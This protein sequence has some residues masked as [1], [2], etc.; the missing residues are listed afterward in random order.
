[1]S[2]AGQPPRPL[3]D[4]LLEAL[5]VLVLLGLLVAA[6]RVF[7]ILGAGA[8]TIASVGI[9]LLG[10]TVLANLLE[11]VGLPHLTGY[12]LAG[13]AAGP[14]ALNLVDHRA[15]EELTPV[16]GLALS[17]I[18]LAGG[19]ELRLASLRNGLRSLAWATLWQNLL[20]MA[21]LAAVFLAARPLLPFLKD[22]P[23]AGVIGVGLVWG[24]MAVTR[25]P[26]ATL[27]ILSQ[28]RAKGPLA[29]FTLNFVMTSDV[30]VV[31]LLAVVMTIARPLILPGSDL[32]LSAVRELGVEV[33]GSI[34]VGTTIGLFL[35]AYLRLVGGGLV[36]M[37][38]ALGVVF[39]EVF[40]YL[41]FDWL[42]I[43]MTA[44]FVVQNLSRQGERFVTA[45][46]STGEIVY[47]IFFGVAGAHLDLPVLR[48]L[49][50]V[51]LLFA[52]A[53]GIT[54]W[55]AGR[56]AS[57]YAADP[58]AIRSWGWSG[59]VSQA[60]LALGIAASIQAEFPA[61][62]AG[63]GAL[64]VAT[65]AMNEMVGPVLFKLALDRCGETQGEAEEAEGA[66]AAEAAFEP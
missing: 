12:L 30:V 42:L 16:N 66:G 58:P 26:S 15:V 57:R 48:V 32:S 14:Y 41:H 55:V 29:S 31:V 27:G 39:T 38:V 63:L 3:A 6:R 23:T 4:R 60:G 43:F 13:V 54:S 1:M 61:F 59:L 19:A 56:V 62:G 44:G 51:A 28:T 47:V 40:D 35:A 11:L 24:V 2:G 22:V 7:P 64:A 9:L 21:A 45:I 50:P 8:G 33:L 34:S 65:V 20:V 49:W 17:L 10:G 46:E 18:A 53:R 52:G 25:S 5:V 36:V 37:L